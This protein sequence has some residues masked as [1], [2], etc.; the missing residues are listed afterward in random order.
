MSNHLSFEMPISTKSSVFSPFGFYREINTYNLAV[1][2]ASSSS[3]LFLTARDNRRRK[4][5]LEL[6]TNKLANSRVNR[7]CQNP[8][9]IGSGSPQV[10]EQAEVLLAEGSYPRET[11]INATSVEDQADT[12]VSKELGS[13]A[14]II[15]TLEE[16]KIHAAVESDP[17]A[18]SIDSTQVEEQ[19]EVQIVE[20]Y[21]MTQFCDKMIE[22]F[23][24]EKPQTKDWRQLLIFREEW[25]KYRDSFYYRCQVRADADNDFIMKQKLVRLRRKVKKIDDE[26]EKHDELLKEIQDNPNDLNAVVA[27]RR[28]DFTGDFFHHLNLLSNIYDG[29]EDCD[30]LVRLG[31]KCLSAVR[32]Y[33]NAIEDMETLMAAQAKFDEILNSPSLDAAREKIK[34]MAK[35]KELDSSLIMLINK[36]WATAKGSEKMTNEAKNIMYHIYK[37][38]KSSLRSIAPKEIKLLKYLLNITDPEERFSALATAFCPGDEHER[39]DADMIYSTP[40]ELH[41]WI[42][43]MLDAYHLNKE[44]TDLREAKQMSDPIVIQRLFILKDSIEKEYL[45]HQTEPDPE[46]KE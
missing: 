2:A 18:N 30:A 11:S 16:A 28:M 46:K 41:K 40:K 1:K 7:S 3:S 45:Q 25:N 29:L 35:E 39:K 21:T 26:M 6:I 37:A 4:N 38:T 34:T 5:S 14:A 12:Q 20:G 22:V 36:A 13:K 9:A 8:Q 19:A 24:N 32:A 31:A 23:L 33:D 43:I 10:K 27:R 17:K 42:K 15:G 44:E